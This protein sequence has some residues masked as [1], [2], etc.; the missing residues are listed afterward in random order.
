MQMTRNSPDLLCGLRP[1]EVGL[2][3]CPGLRLGLTEPN[4]PCGSF[5]GVSR[6][7]TTMANK[8]I[9]QMTAALHQVLCRPVRGS[10]CVCSTAVGRNT[11]RPSISI[12]PFGRRILGYVKGCNQQTGIYQSY[13][14]HRNCGHHR[15]RLSICYVRNH[16]RRIIALSSGIARSTKGF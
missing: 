6:M 8:S 13:C 3:I 1:L 4:S 15:L 10:D 9:I 5:E 2:S 16:D 14:H 12:F 7:L 11:E